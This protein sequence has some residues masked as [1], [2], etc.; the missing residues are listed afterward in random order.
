MSDALIHTGHVARLTL[1]VSAPLLWQF[2]KQGR[3][4]GDV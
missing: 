4:F 2:V 1:D 3:R